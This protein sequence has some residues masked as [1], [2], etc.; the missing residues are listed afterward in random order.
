MTRHAVLAVWAVI[1]AGVVACE[2][3]AHL[4]VTL[5]RRRLA[6]LSDV[7]DRLT[8][9]TWSLVVLFVGWM[10]LGWHLFAR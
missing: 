1:G 6:S 2:V 5:G 9:R 7:L 3:A 4:P 10:W 8:C